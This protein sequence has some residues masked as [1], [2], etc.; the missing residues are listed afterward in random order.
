MVD[1]VSY[2]GWEYVSVIF[3]DND[4]G[5]SASNAFANSAMKYDICIDKKIDISS[6][7]INKTIGEVC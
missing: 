7:E 5:I 3:S 2:F 1:L 4:Y 6:S